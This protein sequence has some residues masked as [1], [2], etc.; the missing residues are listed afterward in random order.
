MVHTRLFQFSSY[1]FLLD[2]QFLS[3]YSPEHVLYSIS[4]GRIFIESLF[5]NLCRI[6]FGDSDYF[7]C[8]LCDGLGYLHVGS[9]DSDSGARTTLLQVRLLLLLKAELVALVELVLQEALVDFEDSE[10]PDEGGDLDRST[11]LLQAPFVLLLEV[12][13]EELVEFVLQE[14]LV[15]FDGSDCFYYFLGDASFSSS[16]LAGP[17]FP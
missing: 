10:F 12:G 13:L 5:Y 17:H 14:V 3:P 6:I 9:E 16:F 1:S 15:G 2:F 8:S 7:Y 4:P 11:V